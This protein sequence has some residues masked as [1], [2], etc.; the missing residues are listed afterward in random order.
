MTRPTWIILDDD[1]DVRNVMKGM[2]TV[3]DIDTI[4]LRNGHEAMALLDQISRA[5]G[6][7]T[8]PEVALL[9]LRLPGPTGGEIAHR[10]RQMPYFEATV[11]VL[12]T[13]FTLQNDEQKALMRFTQAD[14][15]L[16][17]PLPRL[18]EFNRQIQHLIQ[19]RRQA[20]NGSLQ[21]PIA[22]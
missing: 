15:F 9:D 1:T 22:R 7:Q 11:I 6:P 13:A 14:L 21:S 20:L 8:A 3:W 18:M 19:V 4:E 5:E 16:H 2:C 17:K 12:V 10:M